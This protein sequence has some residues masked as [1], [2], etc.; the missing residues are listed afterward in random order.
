MN[1]KWSHHSIC[2]SHCSTSRF[3]SFL[4]PYLVPNSRV[5][6]ASWRCQLCTSGQSISELSQASQE[7]IADELQAPLS[8]CGIVHHVGRARNGENCG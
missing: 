3:C 6:Q 1:H 5:S 4:L 8:E 7:S 2:D